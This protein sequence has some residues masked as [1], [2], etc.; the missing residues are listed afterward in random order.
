MDDIGNDQNIEMNNHDENMVDHNDGNDNN[1]NDNNNDNGNHHDNDDNGNNNEEEAANRDQGDD[2][3]D[4]D[5]DDADDDSV[6]NDNIMDIDAVENNNNDVIDGGVATD[7]LPHERSTDCPMV[8]YF[9]CDESLSPSLPANS[10]VSIGLDKTTKLSAVFERFCHFVSSYKSPGIHIDL[11]DFEFVHCSI[12]NPSDNVETAALMKDDRIRVQ[13]NQEKERKVEAEWKKEIRHSDRT[14]FQQMRT[15][16]PDLNPSPLKCDV[17]FHCEGKIKDE[18]GYK[19]EVLSPFVR[20]HSS[21]I[22]KRCTWLAKKIEAAKDSSDQVQLQEQAQLQEQVHLR[23]HNIDNQNIQNIF[24][25]YDNDNDSDNNNNNNNNN[26]NI[27]INNSNNNNA[28]PIPETDGA[29]PS[30]RPGRLSGINID[31]SGNTANEVEDDDDDENDANYTL[32]SGNLSVDCIDFDNSENV[33]SASPVI[34]FF[35]T[36]HN[37]IPKVALMHPPEAVKLLLEYCYTNRVI[38]LGYEAFKMAHIPI[39]ESTVQKEMREYTGPVEPYGKSSWPN[40]GI[41]TVNLS[42]ALAGIKLA[43]EAGLSRLSLMC[44][45]AASQLVTST[46]LLEALA[47]CEEQHRSSGNQLLYLRKAVMLYHI[48]GHGP[49]GVNDLSSM[50]SFQRTLK[51]RSDVVVPSLM[52]GVFE[53]IKNE[54]GTDENDN[55]NDSHNTNSTTHYYAKLDEDDKIK[56]ESERTRRRKERWNKR[57]KKSFDPLNPYRIEKKDVALCS[58]VILNDDMEFLSAERND[59]IYA[60]SKCRN[61]IFD[62]GESQHHRAVGKHNTNRSSSRNRRRR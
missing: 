35:G 25:V 51:D 16:L 60:S 28:V 58:R 53:A 62:F 27:N 37:N 19:Q 36:S 59:D 23:Q 10:T 20:G 42:V 55:K 5:G 4:G 39:E 7:Q 22:A 1:D 32:K 17:I 30:W 61:N 57:S 11:N 52:M 54:L 50:P 34:P 14:Y 33:R 45:V 47:L 8:L 46:S 44:E 43:E 13:R 26:I 49:R 31:K 41:P 2:D 3:G 38:P 29:Y 9:E 6:N 12:L 40:T 15:L 21:M 48:L 56:R 24:P 18:Q